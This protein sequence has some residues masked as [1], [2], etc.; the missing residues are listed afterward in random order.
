MGN[1]MSLLTIAKINNQIQEQ[2]EARDDMRF[3]GLGDYNLRS[4]KDGTIRCE[5]GMSFNSKES[6]F[7]K[8]MASRVDR[9]INYR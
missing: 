7:L 1:V 5:C 4:K 6:P 8:K 9:K 2:K 3:F